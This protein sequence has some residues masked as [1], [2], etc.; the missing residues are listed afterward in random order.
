MFSNNKE[1][2]LFQRH[3]LFLVEKLNIVQSIIL[4]CIKGLYKISKNY[5]KNKNRRLP[6][7][8]LKQFKKLQKVNHCKIGI[9]IN[10]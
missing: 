9:T 2:E 4:L 5:L 8:L 1:T 3:A 10:A 7:Q 6:Y